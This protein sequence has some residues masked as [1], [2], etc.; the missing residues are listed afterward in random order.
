M[1]R[2][3]KE[4]KRIMLEP[5]SGNTFQS[6]LSTKRKEENFLNTINK[7]NIKK[8]LFIQRRY[9]SIKIKPKKLNIKRFKEKFYFTLVGWRTRR[10]I[11]Y[12]K[13]LP[14]MRETID[15]AKLRNDILDNDHNDL[16][17][18]QILSQFTSKIKI[19]I[20][21]YEDLSE[22]AVWVK[23]PKIEVK[24]SN[25]PKCKGNTKSIVPKRSSNKVAKPANI[26]KQKL[27]NSSASKPNSIAKTFVSKEESD[28]KNKQKYCKEIK[29]EES[30]KKLEKPNKSIKPKHEE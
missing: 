6:F 2:Q 22:N 13:S 30:Q 10:I 7:F 25:K 12:L 23:K 5:L 16:F 27:E 11:S 1:S 18:K 26:I 3:R 4:F 21:K 14:E 9:R 28:M 24:Q 17:S 8:I 29:L 15:F 19:F 20:E